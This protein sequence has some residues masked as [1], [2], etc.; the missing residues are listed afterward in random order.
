MNPSLL[1]RGALT[2]QLGRKAALYSGAMAINALLGVYVYIM[3]TRLLS[4]EAFGMYSF[5]IAFFL[6]S[7]MFFDFGIAPAG[8]R[9][10]ATGTEERERSTTRGALFLLSAGIGVLYVG[11]VAIASFV[12]DAFIRPG[13]GGMLLLAAPL[14]IVYPLQEMVLSIA[15]GESR[16]AALSLA[17]VLPRLLFVGAL[18]LLAAPVISVETAIIMTLLCI[19]VSVAVGIALLR[20]RFHETQSG[21]A[22]VMKEVR[23]FGRDVYAGRIVD[24]LTVGLD[25]IILTW[26]H[27]PAINAYYSIALTMSMPIGIGSKALSH[28]A[29]RRFASEPRIPRNILLASLAWSVIGGL[30]IALGG[31]VLVPL[32]FTS[33]YNP[34]LAVLPLLALGAALAAANHPFHAYLAARRHGRA[35]RIMSMTTSGINVA[36][37]FTL[38]PFLGMTGA[39]IA[40]ITTYAVNIVMNV[41]FYRKACDDAQPRPES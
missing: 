39:A 27:G 8:M 40:F 13:A 20:P 33:S 18:A 32:F 5:A 10:M 1:L 22:R 28:S 9:L 38:I 24:G 14:A 37:N 26:L 34:A 4:V 12:V 6:L 35:I 25:K 36:L 16:M 21:L 19:G 17:T 29:Y 30:L 11:T 15:Q 41:W 7:G 23:E 2:S 31:V 3:L